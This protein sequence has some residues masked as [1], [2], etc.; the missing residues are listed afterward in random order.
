MMFSLMRAGNLYPPQYREVRDQAQ[1]AIVVTLLNEER[2]PVW[3]QVSDWMDRNGPIN[4][5]ALCQIAGLDTLKASK[6]LQR[7]VVQGL[8]VSD[9]TRGKR[10]TVYRKPSQIDV[11]LLQDV[12]S[13]EG[14]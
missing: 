10:N 5:S 14:Q 1:E 13:D 9:D 2:P 7:W 4:N 6:L 12:Q 8:L 11:D 3:E